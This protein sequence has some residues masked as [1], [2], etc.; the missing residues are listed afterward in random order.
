MVARLDIFNETRISGHQPINPAFK[1]YYSKNN[2]SICFRLNVS[3]DC[4]T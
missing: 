2:L 1:L 4:E 3:A